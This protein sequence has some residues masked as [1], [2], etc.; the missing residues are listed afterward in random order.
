MEPVGGERPL[1]TSRFEA[2]DIHSAPPPE[3]VFQ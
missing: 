3:A 1:L 2:Y